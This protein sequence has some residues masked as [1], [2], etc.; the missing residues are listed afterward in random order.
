MLIQP[1]TSIIILKNVPLNKDYMNTL[2]FNT[3]QQQS[4][5]FK[6]LRKHSL[7]KQSYQRYEQGVL[8]INVP[9]EQLYDCNYVMFQNTAFGTKWFYCFITS[10][11]YVN[12]V[13][14]KIM[15][16][17]DVMQ[18]WFFDY[19]LKPCFVER[20]HSNTDN[21]GD[22]LIPENLET[23]DFFL[24]R[25]GVE[26]C[27]FN[28]GQYNIIIIQG[29]D[30]LKVNEKYQCVISN[31][32]SGLDVK[33]YQTPSAAYDALKQIND[34]G[35]GDSVVGVYMVPSIFWG[36]GETSNFSGINVVQSIANGFDNPYNDTFDGYTPKNKKLYTSPY[37]GLIGTS[38]SGDE[39]TY[40]YEY[41]ADPSSPMFGLNFSIGG[42]PECV[43]TPYNYKGVNGANY[44]EE[45]LC[46]DFPQCAYSN[47]V[48]KE[49]IAQN[50]GKLL[51]DF[52]R[53]ITQYAAKNGTGTGELNFIT[54]IY[55][56]LA[57][58]HDKSVLPDKL[59]GSA[60]TYV[61]YTRNIVGFI[62][63]KYKIRREYAE[64][65]DGYFNMFGY[66]TKKVK[67]PSINNRPHW[68][69]I[70]TKGCN[71]VGSLPA[72]AAHTIKSIYDNGIT[73][74][75]DGSEVGDYSL[76]NSPNN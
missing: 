20:E 29:T 38:S 30:K 5:Y 45:M 54:S 39:H 58:L 8:H 64:I 9:V 3:I 49:Y 48:F 65:I 31:V 2:Y 40:S 14:S 42:A 34:D 51:F 46:K 56:T 67:I 50:T 13:S 43:I 68:N 66:A 7:P 12:N 24:E 35:K 60:G 36:E 61:N 41:F 76:D 33:R 70:K 28:A 47:N 63:Y 62:F 52:G 53:N 57:N 25:L 6:S 44:N 19:D 55:G 18:T 16:Q 69:Y 23:G 4:D 15:Y 74:W 21:I 10:V 26:H 71:L 37:M 11:E 17:I 75:V 72:N 1:D 27:P 73:F 59:K 32:F 22:N